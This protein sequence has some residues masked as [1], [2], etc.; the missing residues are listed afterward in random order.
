[1][2]DSVTLA[3]RATT[4]GASPS[5]SCSGPRMKVNQAKSRNILLQVQLGLIKIPISPAK[6]PRGAKRTPPPPSRSH[7]AVPH[8]LSRIT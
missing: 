7:G 8:L 5:A 6:L 4:V 2:L 1:V 3:E